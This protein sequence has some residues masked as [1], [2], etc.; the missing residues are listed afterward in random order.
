M[1]CNDADQGCDGGHGNRLEQCL[2]LR[3]CRARW[4]KTKE[5]G[6]QLFSHLDIAIFRTTL[7]T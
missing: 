1:M 6:L 4:V 2:L 7:P 5:S 3:L